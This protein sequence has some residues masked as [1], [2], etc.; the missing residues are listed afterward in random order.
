MTNSRST[1]RNTHWLAI[2]CGVAIAGLTMTIGCGSSSSPDNT[3]SGGAPGSAGGRTGAGGSSTGAG[4]AAVPKNINYTFDSDVQGWAFST[5]ADTN[6][7][8]LTGLYPIDGGAGD[9]ATP[10]AGAGIAAPTLTWDSSAGMPGL[11]S[12]KISVTFTACNQYVDP[13][14]NF[15]AP[16]DETGLAIS[17]RLQIASGMF[18]GGA[19]LHA[20]TG[21]SFAYAFAPVSIPTTNGTFSTATLTS[22]G[23]AVGV[24]FSMVDGIGL[25]IYSGSVC[26]YPNAGV[27]VVFNLDTFV[28]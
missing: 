4:G 23:Q 17:G 24:D 28:D 27:P 19:Q 12:L 14:I 5:F 9:A 6:T 15:M 16:R 8:N 2:V 20:T 21:T 13:G 7:T 26:P 10:D 18:S 11:G 25:Q 1:P 3:G 22:A